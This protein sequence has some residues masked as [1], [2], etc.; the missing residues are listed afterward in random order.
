MD[1]RVVIAR[2]R[3]TNPA[4]HIQMT[5]LIHFGKTCRQVTTHLKIRNTV[6]IHLKAIAIQTAIR[7]QSAVIH[8]HVRRYRRCV[9]K[10]RRAIVNSQ[11]A[12]KITGHSQ[13]TVRCRSTNDIT[14]DRSRTRRRR[15]QQRVA[16]HTTA[17]HR[18]VAI[19]VDRRHANHVAARLDRR[20]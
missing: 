10:C 14:C 20:H 3:A 18:Q 15:D 17:V 8:R 7:V 6:V 1:Q 9:R 12:L 16:Q 19:A 13:R 2:Q 5:V 11:C 4:V